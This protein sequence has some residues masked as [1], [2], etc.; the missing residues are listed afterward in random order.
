MNTR[1]KTAADVARLVGGTCHG[2][3]EQ[4]VTR[5]NA[6]ADATASD[7]AYVRNERHLR[8]GRRSKAG[9][10]IVPPEGESWEGLRATALVVAKRPEQAMASVL[11][12]FAPAAILPDEAIHETAVIDPTA[13]I[14]QHAKIGPRVWIGAHAVVGDHASLF[15]GASVYPYAR[16]GSHVLL[17]AGAVVRE[18]CALGD[19]VVLHAGAVIGSDGFGFLSNESS[20]TLERT[21][22]IGDVRVGDGVEIGAHT[23]VDRAKFG[24]TIIGEGTKIDNL[25]Q[26][27]HNVRIDAHCVV[28]AQS[29]L[30]GSSRVGSGC[31]LGAQVGVADHVVVGNGCKVAASSGLMRDVPSGATV[32]GTPAFPLRETMRQV[33]ALQ[34]LPSLMKSLRGVLRTASS[35]AS[36]EDSHDPREPRNAE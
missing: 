2:N 31:A 27:A 10:L 21:P 1:P 5:P 26:V 34:R 33:A 13:T 4:P 22:H 9:T 14:G 30:A 32:G 24:S 36:Q 23:C 25:V 17:H 19:H 28:A 20:G 29:G 6:L 11:Q 3:G 16:L 7:V 8:E 15:A 35:E 12:A 18:H